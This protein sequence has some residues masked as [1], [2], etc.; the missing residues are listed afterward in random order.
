MGAMFISWWKRCCRDA[1]SGIEDAI[2]VNSMVV[3]N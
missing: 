2:I 1:Q 3:D